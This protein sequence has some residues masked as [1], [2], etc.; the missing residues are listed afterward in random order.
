LIDAAIESYRNVT[1]KEADKKL[2]YK[3]ESTDIQGM[4]NMNCFL[5]PVII[6]ATG[7]VS[8]SF[9]KSVNNTWTTFNNFYTKNAVV[10]HHTS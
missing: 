2:E 6:G 5:I 9:K 3:N 1:Q 8:K 4:W 10:G 7:M